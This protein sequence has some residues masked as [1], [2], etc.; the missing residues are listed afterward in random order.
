MPIHD[1]IIETAI[2]FDDVLL[3]PSY[4]EVLP[5]QVSLKSRLSDKITLKVPIVS[6][7]MDTVTEASLAI[8]LARVGGLGFIHKNMPIEEQANQVNSVK[9]SENGMISD[10]VT[11]SKEHTL[12]EAKEMMA[13]YKI[14]GLPVVDEENKLVGIIT[15]R[16]V[17]YQEN[18][19]LKV[20]E[21]MTKDNLIVSH[22]STTLEEAKEILLKNRV[23]KLPIVD[24]ENKLVGL[25]TIKDID[26]QL[27][28]PNANKD[29]N[30]RLIVGAGVGVG[31]DT[32][33]RVKALVKAGVD[34][35]A[36]D[37]AHGH[38]EG[39]LGKIREIHA[40][41]PNLDIVGGNIVTAEAAKDLIEAGANV[42][43][44][45]VGPGSICTTRVVAGV[46]VPQLSAIYN[47]YEYAKT[48]N[49]AVIADG[50]I[51][52]SGDIVKAIASGAGAV[53]LGSLLAGTEEA[54]GDEIIFQG[55]KFKSYQG[56]GSLAAMKRGGK[57]R[58]FQSEA[59]KF[60]PEGIEGRVPFKGKL[61]EVIFQLSGGLRA[62]MG[63]CGAKD[64]ESLQKDSRMVRITGSG[65]KESH[66]HD[67]I[68]TQE[69]PNYSL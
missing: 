11:L 4:S 53:M 35:I 67:V 12:G 31:V 58:Y 33:D 43:K 28:Y 49:V 22:K 62:G 32:M 23:E 8:A 39:V 38:S 44:V 69:A 29:E 3:V 66:P 21:I 40:A 57:E 64:I 65:L 56:M 10:P 19:G 25:I 6:A 1:K 41:Y 45:G 26:N 2:T 54:P 52:L 34:I 63:Y 16:D 46:G 13:H 14:S 30:G 48:Q 55:R 37:S 61:E 20:E 17:K 59:K 42:L 51:K 47:V 60:V 9:R 27:E 5:N 68:I 15:N 24:A 50:G 18:L 36:V 7:A